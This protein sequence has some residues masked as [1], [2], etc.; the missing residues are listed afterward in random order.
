MR[1]ATDGDY[2]RL[3]LPGEY[4]VTA[5]AQGYIASS[6][7]AK[8]EDATAT[9]VNFVLKKAKS[10]YSGY[11]KSQEYDQ[12]AHAGDK[13]GA[14]VIPGPLF[15]ANFR[16]QNS[17]PPFVGDMPA[18][19]MMN[20]GGENIGWGNYG[21]Q[22]MV[23]AGDGAVPAQ[24]LQDGPTGMSDDMS[25]PVGHLET[26]LDFPPDVGVLPNARIDDGM[27][28]N[29][30]TETSFPRVNAIESNINGRYTS[31]INQVDP[32]TQGRSLDTI[33][34][35][36]PYETNAR[37]YVDGQYSTSNQMQRD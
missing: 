1:T 27:M 29:Y 33:A 5:S 26:G 34:M 21:N 16:G 13:P 20:Q 7:K 6:K 12:M 19:G 2:W 28:S 35:S 15:G 31:R 36:S 17:R 37:D 14:G 22:E 10:L 23:G 30:Q 3:L 8:V 11:S 25:N 18:S 32:A 24:T 9:H 4:V